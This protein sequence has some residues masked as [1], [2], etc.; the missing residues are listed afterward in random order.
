MCRW[1]FYTGPELCLAD[2]I[3][4]PT[5][6]LIHQSYHARLRDEPLNG[7]GFGVAWFPSNEIAE[8]SGNGAPA[9]FRSI[10]PA[11]NNL[12]LRHLARATSSRTIMAHVRAATPGLGVSEFNCHPFAS[13]GPHK[14]LA[15]MHNGVVGDF[16]NHKRE[17][18]NA[19]PDELFNE[20]EGTTDSEHLFRL[21]LDSLEDE[22]D[23]AERLA[24]GLERA[25]AR[26]LEMQSE[27]AQNTLNLCVSDGE[28]TAITRFSSGDKAAE[29]LFVHEGARYLCDGDVCKMIPA[30]P[31][32][33]GAVIVASEPLS[34]QEGW[35]EI[36]AGSLLIIRGHEIETRAINL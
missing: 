3:T 18:Q 17:M 16:L 35:R 1:I 32:N 2:L 28:H 27:S 5:H 34:D 23:P 8:L 25:I 31:G 15:F 6:S 12:N 4:R 19:L 9:R 11:W 22:G 36:D 20:I 7:D 33:P 14:D 26:T 29:S 21:F 10:Q 13:S 24:R 30:E